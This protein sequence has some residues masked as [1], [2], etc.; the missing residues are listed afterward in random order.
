MAGAHGSQGRVVSKDCSGE[1]QDQVTQDLP[2]AAVRAEPGMITLTSRGSWW[3][4]DLRGQWWSR[5]K[6]QEAPATAQVKDVGDMDTGAR[7]GAETSNCLL[8][9]FQK[10]G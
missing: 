9:T 7:V 5:V 4:A 6:H 3:K 1:A 8:D 2:A 10:L